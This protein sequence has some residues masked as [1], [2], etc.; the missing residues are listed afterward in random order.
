M[1]EGY[2]DW[3]MRDLLDSNEKMN[4]QL[5]LIADWTYENVPIIRT[6]TW[7]EQMRR[8]STPEFQFLNMFIMLR[9]IIWERSAIIHSQRNEIIE[10]KKELSKLKRNK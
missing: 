1:D 2:Y 5:K 4:A 3:V 7:Q 10:L 8:R 6:P 9:D